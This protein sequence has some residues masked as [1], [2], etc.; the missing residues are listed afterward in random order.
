MSSEAEPITIRRPN[1]GDIQQ[2]FEFMLACDIA[3]YGE[4]DS[5]FADLKE[6]WQAADLGQDA[7]VALD[8]SEA[9]L[10]YALIS[11]SRGDLELDIYAHQ[12]RTPPG[13]E[14]ELLQACQKRAAELHAAGQQTRL[15]GYLGSVNQRLRQAFESSG[16]TLYTHHYRMQIDFSEPL[17]SPVWPEGFCLSAFQP[18]DE[19]GL[20]DLIYS[21]F[22]WPGRDP[23]PPVFEDWQ[24]RLF[25]S[26]RFDPELFLVL[27]RGG[28][29]VGAALGYD[30]DER[31]W[32]RQ[33]AVAKDL[34]GQ[35]H[36][37]RLLRAILSIFSQ[38]GL[39]YAAL[40]VESEN[41]HAVEF[42]QRCGMQPTRDFL[43]YRK[44][45]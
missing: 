17:P 16:F 8:A 19:R 31:G 36:G 12:Q 28:A 2:V 3:D 7:W 41:E 40:G 44:Y 34:Q 35:G 24:R 1:P 4:P 27:R 30:E 38:R 18:G 10:G 11:G 21:V 15:R 5:D 42:Y 23:D 43:E 22:T 32:I 9:V 39:G 14:V 45:L 13:L 25:R 29:I 20:Y 6:Q 33:L 37:A 26:G